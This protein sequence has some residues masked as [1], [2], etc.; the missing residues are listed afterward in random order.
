MLQF[1]KVTKR[2]GARLRAYY[3]S[4][5]YGLCEYSVGVKLMWRGSLRPSW[6]EAAGCLIVQNEIGGR[7]VFDYPVPGPEGDEDAALEA[8][9]NDCMEREILPVI[10]VVPEEKAAHLL[11]RYPYVHVSNVRTWQDY[12][13]YRE[14]LQFFAGRRYS[15][16][17]NHINKF[18]AKWPEAEFR[19]LTAADGAVI[20]AFWVDYE[21][22]FPK[23]DNQK[24]RDELASSKK[25]LGMVGKSWF[26][27]GG[28]FIGEKLIA[29]SLAEICGSTLI[30][31]IE[32][33]LYSYAG[34]YPALVQAF[35]DAFGEGCRWINREDDAA[36]R[37]LRT[38][39]LQYGP[40]KLAPKYCF[41]P[42]NELLSHVRSIPELK[43]E[44]LT[45]SALTQEDIPAYNALVLDGE[46]N[47]WW[48]YDDVAGLKAP[49]EERSFFEVA[50]RDF[51]NRQAVNFAIRLDGQLIGEAVLY[52]FDC[53]GGAELGCR[54]DKAFGGHGY[55]TEAFS[56]VADWALYR[57]HLSRVLAKCFRENQAS[58][59]MLSSCMRKSG[60]DETFFYFEKLV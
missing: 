25:M 21:A 49:M 58:Y 16:Q 55:G 13:Y 5:D 46:R 14:D 60:E 18:R 48:G 37:G 30:I 28:M 17:R 34:V 8:I 50:Q 6:T 52:R 36:D 54:I 33:A 40:A 3:R 27:C 26:L 59:Q 56:A 11:A 12:M 44:R 57:V 24:A 45:L 15:G 22:E 43:T 31:H 35:A 20:E 7:V 10:S 29:L 53:R 51:E 47:R 38:S 41:E 19:P 4:C 39:K 32:K 23:G 2:D 42:Q 9:E 1:K